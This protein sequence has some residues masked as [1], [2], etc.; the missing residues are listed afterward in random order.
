MPALAAGQHAPSFS[1]PTADGKEFSLDEALAHGPVVLAFFKVSCPVCQYAFPYIDRLYKALNKRGVTV[2]GVSQDNARDTA[3]FVKEFGLT[4]PIALEPDPYPVATAYDLTNV[5]TVIEVGSDGI[6]I[7]SSV[8]WDRADLESIYRH[9]ADESP[10]APAPLF[11]R[12]EKVADFKA[13]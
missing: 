7:T 2:I 11:Q 8:G 6:I 5:P 4:L 1:L 13:G 3:E 9:S 12:G 10:S